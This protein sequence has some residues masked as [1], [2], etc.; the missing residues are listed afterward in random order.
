MGSFL[1][2][3]RP[4]VHRLPRGP[5]RQPR[6]FLPALRAALLLALLWRIALVF[7]P[8]LLSSDVNRYVWEGRVQLHGGNPY[9]WSD[10]PSAP[11]WQGLRDSV[12][13][14]LNHPSYT[15]IY[16]P[17]WQMA[18]VRSCGFTTGSER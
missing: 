6:P 4:G 11:Q 7:T 9:A 18:A 10:R 17:L 3:F 8:P 13:A 12:Y 1:I 14:G 2:L 15:A 16:P 5:R